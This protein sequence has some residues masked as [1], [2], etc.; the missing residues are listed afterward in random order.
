MKKMSLVGCVLLLSAV[1][2]MAQMGSYLSIN[3]RDS[4]SWWSSSDVSRATIIGTLSKSDGIYTMTDKSGTTYRL[5]GDTAGLRKQVGQTIMVTGTTTSR[6]AAS[7]NTSAPLPCPV[8]AST[9]TK[10]TP[11]LSAGT[12]PTVNVSSF[13]RASVDC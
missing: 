13:K 8:G 3:W 9:D 10:P 6:L 1:G 12:Q 11:S 2:A 7:L 5:T 4:A